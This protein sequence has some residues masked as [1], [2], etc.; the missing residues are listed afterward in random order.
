MGVE[1]TDLLTQ[2]NW[3]VAE[4]PPSPPRK[5]SGNGGKHDK[6]IDEIVNELNSQ[7]WQIEEKHWKSNI[8]I[9]NDLVKRLDHIPESFIRAVVSA[10]L[11]GRY[12][13]YERYIVR[14]S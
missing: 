1:M 12:S 13:E 11:T 8:H 2:L 4:A 9:G 5:K 7:I 6:W 14:D 3:K 10:T